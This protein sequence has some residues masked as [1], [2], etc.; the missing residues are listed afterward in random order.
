MY[1][2]SQYIQG[3]VL[4]MTKNLQKLSPATKIAQQSFAILQN[5]TKISVTHFYIYNQNTNLSML[6]SGLSMK[7]DA[8][9]ETK[10]MEVLPI[11]NGVY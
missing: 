8:S 7:F 3:C 11:Y 5:L 4:S 6:K 10:N 2:R 1:V 9:L